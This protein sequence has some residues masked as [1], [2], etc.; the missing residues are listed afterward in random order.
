VALERTGARIGAIRQAFNVREGVRLAD[1]YISPRATGHPPL[2]SGPL[3]GVGIDMETRKR[4]LY[5]ARGWDPE[6]GRPLEDT[7]IE[8]DLEHIADDLYGGGA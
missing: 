8:L 5:Q 4:D 2:K 1:V 6:A 7:L 3:A